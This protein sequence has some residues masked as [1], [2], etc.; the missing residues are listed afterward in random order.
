[1]TARSHNPRDLS[2]LFTANELFF[3]TRKIIQLCKKYAFIK[4][5]LDWIC[6][7]ETSQW[8]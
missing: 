2:P 8:I 6:I 3:K 1:M 5:A 7:S 4:V